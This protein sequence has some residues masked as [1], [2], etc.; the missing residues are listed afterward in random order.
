MDLPGWGLLWTKDLFTSP[1][2]P[3]PESCLLHTVGACQP[4]T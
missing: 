4:G 2:V 1:V 3:Q